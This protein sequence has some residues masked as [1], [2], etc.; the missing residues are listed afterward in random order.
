LEEIAV[1][2]QQLK[3]QAKEGIGREIEK[4]GKIIKELD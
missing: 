1:I 4:Q 3:K 2:A